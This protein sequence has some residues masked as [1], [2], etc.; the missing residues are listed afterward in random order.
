MEK[1]GGGER[2]KRIKLKIILNL[3]LSEAV[4]IFE[5]LL[6]NEE[7]HATLWG[8]DGLLQRFAVFRQPRKD[9]VEV[10]VEVLVVDVLRLASLQVQP[11]LARRRWMKRLE[12]TR[13]V[14]NKVGHF[15]FVH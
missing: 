13:V 4:E 11:L 9:G 6:E 3:R 7:E 2:E 8:R 10:V 15:E 1:E 12:Q 14:L 5:M